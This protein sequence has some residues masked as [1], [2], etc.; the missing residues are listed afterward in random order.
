ML[1][2]STRY[3]VSYNHVGS[4][5]DVSTDRLKFWLIAHHRCVAVRMHNATTSTA[6]DNSVVQN[7]TVLFCEGSRLNF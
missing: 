2:H 1:F 6:K 5:C 4:L 3:L 7:Y